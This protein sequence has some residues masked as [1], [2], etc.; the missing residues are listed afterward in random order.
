MIGWHYAIFGLPESARFLSRA[1]HERRPLRGSACC[2]VKCSPGGSACGVQHKAAYYLRYLHHRAQQ[3][4]DLSEFSTSATFTTARCNQ[5]RAGK[6]VILANIVS[7]EAKVD[8]V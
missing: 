2:E 7:C 3:T 6:E 8:L 4:H 5:P 1:G